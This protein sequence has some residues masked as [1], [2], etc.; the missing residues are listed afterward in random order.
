MKTRGPLSSQG[1]FLALCE[2][3]HASK[4][5][6]LLQ[7]FHSLPSRKVTTGVRRACVAPAAAVRSCEMLNVELLHQAM[8]F[9]LLSLT[10]LSTFPP[11]FLP[12]VQTLAHS[13]P[14]ILPHSPPSHI[15]AASIV[16][17]RSLIA[18]LLA[19]ALLCTFS[20][21]HLVDAGIVPFNFDKFLAVFVRYYMI[22]LLWMHVIMFHVLGIVYCYHAKPLIGY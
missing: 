22:V 13:P 19:N 3:Q 9:F 1:R 21:G 12:S 8:S 17:R 18:S 14:H 4:S 6:L 2:R 11:P 16:L 20:S 10:H 15:P 5:E 7:A